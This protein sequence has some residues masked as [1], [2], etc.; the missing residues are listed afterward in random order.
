[1]RC[2]FRLGYLFLSA[3]LLNDFIWS[4]RNGLLVSFVFPEKGVVSEVESLCTLHRVG[5]ILFGMFGLKLRRL[6]FGKRE[7]VE[8]D[9]DDV[10]SM[11]ILRETKQLN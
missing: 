7:I 10:S 3:L 9:V 4:Y 2:G 6:R 11:M 8:D 1:M 5:W